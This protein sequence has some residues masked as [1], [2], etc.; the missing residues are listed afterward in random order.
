MWKRGQ[1]QWHSLNQS[2]C[3]LGNTAGSLTNTD[4]FENL[5]SDAYWSGTVYA[6]V[7]FVAWEFG[8]S[9]GFQIDF[10][11]T[12]ALYAVAVRPGDVAAHVAAPVSEPQTFGLALAGLAALL[13]ARRRR[14]SRV[15]SNTR[16][17]E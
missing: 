17:R 6:P 4:P 9:G 2:C 12:N 10:S 5:Q 15:T 7:T 8:T 11:K 16:Q 1:T 3:Q 13:V 14:P